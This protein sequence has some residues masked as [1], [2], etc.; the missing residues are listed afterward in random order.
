MPGLHNYSMTVSQNHNNEDVSKRQETV[1]IVTMRWGGK[2][3]E[4]KERKEFNH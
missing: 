2:K 1:V 3:I 4:T